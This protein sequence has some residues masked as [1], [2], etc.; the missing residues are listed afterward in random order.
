MYAGSSAGGGVVPAGRVHG[1]LAI[2]SRVPAG[3]GTLAWQLTPGVVV[4]VG[5]SGAFHDVSEVE[6][7]R[8]V[9]ELTRVLS[10]DRWQATKPQQGQQG[11]RLRR[12]V[13]Q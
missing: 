10:P 2:L 7:L 9:A 13:S 11:Q 6:G 8:R 4:F 12:R 5:I 3:N 1:L